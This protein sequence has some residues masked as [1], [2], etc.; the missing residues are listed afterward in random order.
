MIR[1][2]CLEL[3]AKIGKLQ[4]LSTFIENSMLKFGLSEYQQFQT[5]I[6][7][8]EV[9]KNIITHADLG[10]MDKINVKC[11]EQDNEIKILIE[12]P[13]KPFN[14]V[15]ADSKISPLKQDDGLKVYFIKKNMNN[16]NRDFEGG[17]NV[18]TLIKRV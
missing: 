4:L 7:V 18:L 14:P 8:D 9:I 6:A 10:E 12:Y 11:Q 2:T 15:R 13:G 16:V 3:R 1:S 5:Q 17:K